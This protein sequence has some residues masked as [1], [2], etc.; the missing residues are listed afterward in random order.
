MDLK[1]IISRTVDAIRVDD[2]SAMD[3]ILSDLLKTKSEL[4]NSSAKDERM[5]GAVLSMLGIAS[6]YA[7][8]MIALEAHI[9][10]IERVVKK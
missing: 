5:L 2:S 9:K 8:D 3:F 1:K 6:A 10:E 4:M 7:E